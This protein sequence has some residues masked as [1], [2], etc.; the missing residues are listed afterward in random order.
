MVFEHKFYGVVV[1]T[2]D[3][4]SLS[5][6]SILSRTIPFYL[7]THSIFKYKIIN[8]TNKSHRGYFSL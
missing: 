1:S 4:K 8:L 6:S 3:F 7:I 5:L 2:E